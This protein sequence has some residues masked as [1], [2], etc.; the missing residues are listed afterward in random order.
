M[1]PPCNSVSV[2]GRRRTVA[3]SLAV[4]LVLGA[5]L[6]VRAAA[7]Q[8]APT[9]EL[10]KTSRVWAKDFDGWDVEPLCGTSSS[11]M[12]PA[13]FRQG[14]RLESGGGGHLAVFPDGTAYCSAGTFLYRVTT[15]GRVDLVAGMPGV[16]GW[17]DGPADRALFANI[18]VLKM[19]PDG[20]LYAMEQG[21]RV[22]RKI[23]VREDAVEVSTVAGSPQR[24]ARRVDGPVAEAA[25]KKPCGMT[26][27][28]DG[29][30]FV[31]DNSDLRVI[32]GGR[33]RTLNP[34]GGFGF[35][36][37][38]LRAARFKILFTGNC[39]TSD[40]KNVLYVADMW[41][42]VLRKID[43]AAGVISSI[44]GGP[45]RG[46]PGW[47][48][49]KGGDRFRDGPAMWARFHP[50]GGVTTAYLDRRSGKIYMGVADDKNHVLGPDGWVRTLPG[51]VGLPMASDAQGRIYAGH[52]GRLVR[53]ARLAPGEKPYEPE[54]PPGD[55]K[56]LFVRAPFD[57]G[58]IPADIDRVT[59][60]APARPPRIDGTL[61]DECWRAAAV[62]RLDLPNGKEAP[63]DTATD[64][65][66]LADRKALYLAFTCAEPAMD[67]MKTPSRHRDDGRFY[68]D[69]YVEFFVIPSLDPRAKPY[70]LMVNVAGQTWEG[71]AK[72]AKKWNPRL[73]VA[74]AQWDGAWTVE[75]ELPLETIPG[76]A[77]GQWR[78]NCSRYRPRRARDAVREVSWSKLYSSSSHTYRR[79]N[80]VRVEALA[81]PGGRR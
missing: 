58:T 20:A 16:S 26:I 64:L 80:V 76:S 4:T 10:P 22:V 5:V 41:N 53:L 15:A 39:L 7:G 74:A 18:S 51:R 50:G 29:R 28:D 46:A 30:I 25:F 57:P 59:I 12:A 13:F 77:G 44:A 48:M 56:P 73:S 37:G 55:E 6:L 2:R 40:G 52:R 69:D 66:V 23:V 27:F 81:G 54:R 67:E 3:A 35:A 32:E 43:L 71:V 31:M 63:A 70:Q 42:N 21:T 61:D 1:S 8:E 72:N 60:G 34:K 33:V 36:D 45:P 65:R 79:F 19:G 14:P 68:V 49:P 9:E 78:M 17:R 75:V 11:P 47:G 62:Y 24:R 38:P